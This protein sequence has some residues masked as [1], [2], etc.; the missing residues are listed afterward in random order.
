MERREKHSGRYG[1]AFRSEVASSTRREETEVT[2]LL[3]Y[4][5]RFL[6]WLDSW[7]L[8]AVIGFFVAV[9]VALEAI[10]MWRK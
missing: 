10:S 8:V 3:A 4:W 7:P 2:F 6:Y 5:H 1:K 9:Y